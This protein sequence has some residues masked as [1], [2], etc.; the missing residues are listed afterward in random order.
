MKGARDM[1]SKSLL[2]SIQVSFEYPVV[3]TRGVFAPGNPA[4]ADAIGR[5]GEPRRHR[6]MFFVDASVAAA[7]P[8]LTDRIRGYVAHHERVLELAAAPKILA[9]GEGVKND[10]PGVQGIVEDLVTHRLDRHACVVAVG[11]G[12]LLDAVGFAASLVHRGLRVIRVPTTVL[13][14]N[15]A[16]VGVKTGV[17]FMGGKNML[18]TF[19][20]P[21]AVIN[22]F[23]FL[24]TLPDVAWTDGIAEAFK[25]AIIKDAKFFAWLCD[26]AAALA[27]RDTEAMELLIIRCAELHLEHIRAGGDPFEMG[28]ARPLDFGHWSAHRLEVISDYAVSHGAAVAIGIV[29]DACYAVRKGWLTPDAYEQIRCGLASAGFT[30]WHPLLERRDKSGRL[31]I[32]QGLRDFREHLGGELCITMPRGLGQKFEVHEMDEAHIETCISDMK[33]THLH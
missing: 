25:V 1:T 26:Q 10:M 16:G 17:N 33:T 9:G 15:D 29:L 7:A 21:F 23:E 2:Q 32:L 8:G 18:G 30:L 22:D 27:R 13:G 12:A 28:R 20:P 3:F 11:G 5:L 24:A 14:Q 6:V 31:E 4:L 19:A